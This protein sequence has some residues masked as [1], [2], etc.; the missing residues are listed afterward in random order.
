MTGRILTRKIMM[1]GALLALSGC[2]MYVIDF[3]N[4][5]PDGSVLAPKASMPPP[6]PPPPPTPLEGSDDV[7]FMDST[8]AQLEG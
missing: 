6:A 8:T 7:T 3:E 2:N 1:A 5:L 4:K